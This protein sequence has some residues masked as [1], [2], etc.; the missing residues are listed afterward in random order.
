MTLEQVSPLIQ[1]AIVA[2]VELFGTVLLVVWLTSRRSIV[3]S[4]SRRNELEASATA[5][6]KTCTL[7]RQL[8][9][10]NFGVHCF[11]RSHVACCRCAELFH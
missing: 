9:K 8:T 4:A 3:L 11:C 5:S 7:R 10:V 6:H 2:K 1:S